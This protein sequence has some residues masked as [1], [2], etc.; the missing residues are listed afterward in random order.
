MDAQEYATIIKSI[1]S[2]L[3]LE[4]PDTTLIRNVTHFCKK[5]NHSQLKKQFLNPQEKY[6]YIAQSYVNSIVQE[7]EFNYN[8]YLHNSSKVNES[9]MKSNSIQPLTEWLGNRMPVITSKAMGI[10]IDSRL[11][12]IS[13]SSPTST[14][15]D[16]GFNLVPR[17]TRAEIGDG[18]IQARITPSHV[19][20]FKVGKVIIPYPQELLSLNFAN[21]ITLT[22]TAL[23]S[24]G[25]IAREDTYHFTFSF[26]SIKDNLVELTPTNEYCKFDPPLRIVDDLTLRFNDPIYPIPFKYDRLRPASINYLSSDGR[27]TFNVPHLLSTNDV[28]IVLGLKTLNDAAN[29]EVLNQINNPRGIVVN[30]INSLMISLN[31]DFTR[32]VQQDLTS[33]PWVLF[34]NR[35]FR[36]PLEIGYQDITELS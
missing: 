36:M 16:F 20:Y 28:V 6:E 34:Y 32:I 18:R 14:I 19:T 24:N 35:T 4:S 17:L 13:T 30:V 2:K 8:D 15:T 1:S 11:R 25:I 9:E 33:L 26:K 7:E 27:I 22:F 21:E 29:S 3:N 10:Y 5:L 12:N 31:I 23:R